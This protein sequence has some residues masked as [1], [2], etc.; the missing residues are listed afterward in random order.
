MATRLYHQTHA[1]W[2]CDYHIVWCPKYRGKVLAD[3]YIKLEMKRMFK[4]IAHWKELQI[5][6]WHIGDEH[7]HLHITIPPKYSVAYIIQVLKEKSSTWIK[8]KTKKFPKGP[9]WAKGYFVRTTGLT[10]IRFATTSTTNIITKS[11]LNNKSSRSGSDDRSRP[12][13][14]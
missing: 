6:A 11:N 14:P 8:K 3:T 5:L 9:L 7:I 13:P 4:H 12:A 2:V 1:T 10:S